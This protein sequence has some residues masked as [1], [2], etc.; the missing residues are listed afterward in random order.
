MAHQD[1]TSILELH[2]PSTLTLWVRLEKKIWNN[3]KIIPP[4]T[5]FCNLKTRPPWL[6][7]SKAALKSIWTSASSTPLSN[8]IWPAQTISRRPSQVS[9]KILPV[10]VLVRWQD[11]RSIEKATKT[12]R[13]QPFENLW[14]HAPIRDHWELES[15]L[16]SITLAET[17]H[18]AKISGKVDS[19][20]GQE[21]K[22]SS[23]P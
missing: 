15:H 2:T 22:Q 13:D 21:Q 7:L 1:A 20:S 16:Q 10:C 4:F 3:Y 23:Y 19:V 5:A 9:S 18:N 8:S 11:P 17:H 6:T 14:R 12:Q